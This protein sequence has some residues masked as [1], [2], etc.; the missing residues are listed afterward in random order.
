MNLKKAVSWRH[1]VQ[2]QHQEG[3]AV[4]PGAPCP[5]EQSWNLASGLCEG[6]PWFFLLCHMSLWGRMGCAVLRELSSEVPGFSGEE[7]EPHPSKTLT[8]P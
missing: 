5:E 4:G 2:S 8:V 7:E 3:G 1:P 6:K